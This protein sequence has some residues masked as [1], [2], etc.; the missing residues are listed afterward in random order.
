[1]SRRVEVDESLAPE[2]I[3]GP[4]LNELFAHARETLPE[5]CCGLIV[6]D[7]EVRFLRLVRCRNEA[8]HRH[9]ANPEQYP[10]DGREAFFMNELDYVQAQQ[11]AEIAGERITA[12]YHSHVDAGAYLS[13]QDLDHAESELFPFPDADHVV[14]AVRIQDRVVGQV[15]V[16]RRDRP[17]G[18]FAGRM[19]SAEAE[20]E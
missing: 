3:A 17:M 18:G 9:Q 12:I 19:L 1:M 2:P 7:A 5:E 4:L 10:R 16:F 20:R 8:T 11:Q 14:I 15:G 6:G 13:E